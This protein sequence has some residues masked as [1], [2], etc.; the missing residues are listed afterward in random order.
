MS[1]GQNAAVGNGVVV[2]ADGIHLRYV[3]QG[4]GLPVVF[5]HGWLSCAEHWHQVAA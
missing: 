1:T 3:D 4:A 5:V 2:T